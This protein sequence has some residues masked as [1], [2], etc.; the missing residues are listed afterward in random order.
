MSAPATTSDPV[1]PK[2]LAVRIIGAL[3]QGS[4]SLESVSLFSVGRD[5][6]YRATESLMDDLQLSGGS[7]VRWIK[8]AYGSGKT[9]TFARLLEDA[10]R[11]N[12]VVSY[13]EV[14][15]K[16]GGCELHRFEQVYAGII[17]SCITPEAAS[18]TAVLSRSGNANGWQWVLDEW[19]EG[20]KRQVGARPGADLPTM[21]YREAVGTAVRQ[22]RA[23][24][25]IQG[26]FGAALRVYALARAEADVETC[27][28]L[29]Q[30]FMGDEVFKRGTSV[31]R[32]LCEMGVLETIKRSNAKTMLRQVTAFTRYRG[33][34]GFLILLDEVENVLGETPARRKA[35]YTVLRELIDNVDER[36]GMAGTL[37]WV[38]GTPDLFDDPKGIAEYEALASRVI[39]ETAD[40]TPNPAAVV[41]DLSAF[42]VTRTEYLDIG[43]RVARLHALSY[44]VKRSNDDEMDGR[45]YALLGDA[46]HLPTLRTWV[47]LVVDLLDREGD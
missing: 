45:L 39:L 36:H 6:V 12:W 38:S 30:W 28:L 16:D 32:R 41:L 7:A 23:A 2:A 17:R 33:Y 11:R 24:Y 29:L 21:R 25:A 13:V 20:L 3:R 34:P 40:R 42:P 27:E 4:N 9:H 1:V 8:G 31:R 14:S 26:A 43:R 22:L 46:R 5:R 35:A 44:D 19:V 18:A 37:L 15:G 10:H 47:R